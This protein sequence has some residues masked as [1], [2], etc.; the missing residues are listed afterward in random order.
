[1]SILGK[2]SS[3]KLGRLRALPSTRMSASLGWAVSAS[4]AEDTEPPPVATI[5]ITRPSS[6]DEP[7]K[8]HQ[9]PR[10]SSAPGTVEVHT[11]SD[12]T[13]ATPVVTP[14]TATP[15]LPATC[16]MP[17]SPFE[18][19]LAAT[20]TPSSGPELFHA[21]RAIWREPAQN[22][23]DPTQPNSSRRRLENIM[24]TPGALES[25]ET[26][27]AGI[28][29]VWNGLVGGAR[30]KHRLPLALVVGVVLSPYSVA[31]K[32]TEVALL[33]QNT[34]SRMDS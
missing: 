20:D 21:R 3:T 32:L 11:L 33:D 22:P 5:I 24:A 14:S 18:Q 29:R 6:P 2:R 13:V 23:P 8:S 7:P 31:A 25:D 34:T 30:L 27:G 1:M 12:V 10:S 9:L 15:A 28:D 17:L 16:P 19:R 26:W 4:P